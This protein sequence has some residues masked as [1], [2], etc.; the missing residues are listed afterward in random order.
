MKKMLNL[1]G[2]LNKSENLF[3][4]LCHMQRLQ[5]SEKKQLITFYKTIL[6]TSIVLHR[7]G[8]LPDS[9]NLN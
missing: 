1:N 9:L 2:I 8:D 3:T 7:L 4:H 5:N 6:D